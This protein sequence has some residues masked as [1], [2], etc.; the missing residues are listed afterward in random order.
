[1]SSVLNSERAIK[2][3]IQIIRLF[4]KMRRLLLSHKDLVLKVQQLEKQVELQGE[5][6]Q[7]I[8]AYLKKIWDNPRKPEEK[9]GFKKEEE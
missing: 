5:E 6:I 8:F 9:L 1:M 2:V 4:I 3:N 7:I